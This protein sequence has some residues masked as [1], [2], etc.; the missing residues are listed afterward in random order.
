MAVT[1]RHRASVSPSGTVPNKSQK[2]R[3]PNVTEQSFSSR[4]IALS[5]YQRHNR[6][7]NYHIFP[8]RTLH[9]GGIFLF[10]WQGII[11]QT[12]DRRYLNFSQGRVRDIPTFISEPVSS[13]Q[14]FRQRYLA[15]P[16]S[17]HFPCQLVFVIPGGYPICI[18]RLHHRCR[19]PRNLRLFWLGWKSGEP[20]F[21]I[22]GARMGLWRCS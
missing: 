14:H 1:A 12:R 4:S 20:C 13:G 9:F 19:R 2:R 6:S 17:T 3:H 16:F 7:V 15:R 22:L 5:H 18:W 11:V 10:I 21:G 8:Y